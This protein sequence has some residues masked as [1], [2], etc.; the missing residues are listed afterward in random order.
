VCNQ[1]VTRRAATGRLTVAGD[2]PRLDILRLPHQDGECG[3]GRLQVL[4]RAHHKLPVCGHQQHL[5]ELH[6]QKCSSC[7]QRRRCQQSRITYTWRPRCQRL[8]AT[9]VS[10]R[11][12]EAKMVKHR[13]CYLLCHRGMSGLCACA[14]LSSCRFF[15][16]FDRHAMA[17]QQRLDPIG[18]VAIWAPSYSIATSPVAHSTW[19]NWQTPR[20]GWMDFLDTGRSQRL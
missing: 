14:H 13:R 17:F 4:V 12:K 2:E 10:C 11:G 19:G 20:D 1:R 18:C 8:S 15:D 3:V 9:G 6:M 7:M 16:R 5:M